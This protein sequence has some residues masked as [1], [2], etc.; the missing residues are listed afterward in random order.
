MSRW[1][2]CAAQAVIEAFGGVL[3]K[4]TAFEAR[5]GAREFYTYLQSS[6]NLDFEPGVACLTPYN[7]AASQPP[8]KK[9]DPPVHATTADMVK[10]YSNLCGLLALDRACNE[11]YSSGIYAAIQK[12]KATHPLSYD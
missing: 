2:T 6:E 9:G 10:P 4:L 7:A 5:N 12:I 11:S 1:D 3:C 8:I